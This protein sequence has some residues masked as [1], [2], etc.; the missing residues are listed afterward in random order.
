MT[1]DVTSGR[2]GC[3]DG[4]SRRSFLKVGA[5][6]FG[7]LTLAGQLRRDAFAAA[8]G[9]QTK[10]LSVILLWQGGGPS[11]IDMWD[12]KPNAPSEFRGSFNPISTSIPGYQV[13]EHMPHIAKI[14]DRLAILRSVSHPDS[15]HESASHMLL[16]GYKPTNDIPANEVPSY[17]SIVSYE[18]G[19]RVEG[20]PAYACV[21]RAPKSS[22]AA[23]LGVAYNPFETQGDPNSSDFKVRNL[24]LP[25][26]I[27]LE[28]LQQR[29]EL[30]K[31]FDNLRRDV[32]ASGLIA[33]M[34][35]FSQK[36]FELATSPKVQDAFD[37]S[38]ESDKL[39]DR[40]GRH[41]MGQSTLLARRLVE[42]GVRFVTVDT[43]GWDTHANN[44]ESLKNSKL[45]QFDSCYSAL[46]EDL[47]QR[48]ML[49]KTLV[50]VWGEFGRTP[51]INK[52]AGRDHWPNVMTAV[53]A[54]GGIK[55]GIVLGE[56][57]ARAEFP[58]ERPMTPQDVL[59]TMY[60]Q[61]GINQDISYKNEA[62]RPVSILNYGA[63]IPEII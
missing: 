29:R 35:S 8:A 9:K 18:M 54:G 63:P 38:R 23:Y 25:N 36:A 20:F 11:H 10:D 48:G 27:T 6:A 5:L 62:D 45:P 39:R 4:V 7:G 51:R 13:S 14:C 41:T 60:H 21:P 28:R 24:K 50:L 56:S 58:K 15:G 59:S 53:L 30:L 31:T 37:I 52:D 3:C 2:Y 26:G 19:P 55:R 42:S 49:D 57:D 61:L 40:Y 17:G 44:F 22:A 46:I 12:L 47:D 32:D 43:G 1:I 33:G 34:D 16:T